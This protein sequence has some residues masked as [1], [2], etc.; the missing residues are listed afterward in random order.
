MNFA[1]RKKLTKNKLVNPFDR[2]ALKKERLL[3]PDSN[4]N[5]PVQLQPITHLLFNYSL[6]L[7][8]C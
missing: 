1:S 2:L 7:T 3:K 4:M 8:L 6:E 5:K